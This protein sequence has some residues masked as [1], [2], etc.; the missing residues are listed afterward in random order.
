[1]IDPRKFEEFKKH[2]AEYG[3]IV[4]GELDAEYRR[5]AAK[6]AELDER[7]NFVEV[8]KQ[9]AAAQAEHENAKSAFETYRTQLS[10]KL[11]KW[12]ATLSAKAKELDAKVA[13]VADSHANLQAKQAVHDTTSKAAA[14][15]M[16]KRAAELD[17]R[18]SDLAN[19]AAGLHMREVNVAARETKVESVMSKLS[20]EWRA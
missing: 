2:F 16:T 10:D 18:E 7:E 3:V 9:F 4:K 15:A 19:L 14:D 6:I 13:A 17:K 11:T 8:K 20:A 5:V 1:M 12:E